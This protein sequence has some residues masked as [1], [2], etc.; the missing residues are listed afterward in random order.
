VCVCVWKRGLVSSFGVEQPI[1]EFRGNNLDAALIIIE[2]TNS[3]AW[4]KL[5][6]WCP[7]SDRVSLAFIAAVSAATC[8]IG[9]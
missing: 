6:A 9:H 2:Y 7:A 3:G 5:Q 4:I 1:A 8:A